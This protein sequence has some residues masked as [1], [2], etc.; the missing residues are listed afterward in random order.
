MDAHDAAVPA[1]HAYRDGAGASGTARARRAVAAGGSAVCERRAKRATLRRRTRVG[2]SPRRCESGCDVEARA[3][4][5]DELVER[6]G[7]RLAVLDRVDESRRAR[8][9]TLVL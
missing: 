4:D 9:I 6:D 2:L 1:R 3:R 7:R 5:F 8:G